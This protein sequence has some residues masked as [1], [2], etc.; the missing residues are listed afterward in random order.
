MVNLPSLDVLTPPPI[1]LRPLKHLT[2][3]SLLS[4][5]VSFRHRN[6]ILLES[7]V[8]LSIESHQSRLLI[9]QEIVK[10]PPHDHSTF[11]QLKYLSSIIKNLTASKFRKIVGQKGKNVRTRSTSNTSLCDN[12]HLKLPRKMMMGIQ[13]DRILQ[14]HSFRILGNS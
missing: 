13:M 6:L 7:A 3:L 8:F 2:Q 10:F 9:V 5:S 4:S 14:D 12:S 1:L 11:S